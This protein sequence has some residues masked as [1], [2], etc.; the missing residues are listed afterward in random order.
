LNRERTKSAGGKVSARRISPVRVIA[1]NLLPLSMPFGPVP[2]S[3]LR[4]RD[5]ASRT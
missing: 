2:D 3:E 4:F 5:L 1:R